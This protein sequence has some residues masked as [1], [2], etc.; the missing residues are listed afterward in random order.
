SARVVDGPH[1]PDW[2]A[3]GILDHGV[4]R[5]PERVVRRLLT[6]VARAREIGVERVDGLVAR[7]LEADDARRPTR[8]L[9]PIACEAGAVEEELESTRNVRRAVMW[10]P[11]RHLIGNV[12]A[13]P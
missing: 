1:Q 13:D 6:A 8:A 4:A 3:V 11:L 2:V 12:D 5:S 7:E 10:V 9:V